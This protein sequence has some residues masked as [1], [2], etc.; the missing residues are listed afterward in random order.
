[1]KTFITYLKITALSIIIS[2]YLFQIFL[3]FKYSGSLGQISKRV[4]LYESSTGKKYDRRTKYEV[5]NELK[6]KI[7]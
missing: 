2:I 7:R 1:M 5:Y 3:T 4:S 6:K